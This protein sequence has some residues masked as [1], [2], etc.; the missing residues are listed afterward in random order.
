VGRVFNMMM[1]EVSHIYDEHPHDDPNA[2]LPPRTSR[3]LPAMPS[4]RR[5]SSGASMAPSRKLLISSIS[6]DDNANSG[7]ALVMMLEVSHII[8]TVFIYDEHPHDE[9]THLKDAARD[10]V[11]AEEELRCVDG[12]VEE[13]PDL[14]LHEQEERLCGHG[15]APSQYFVSDKWYLSAT[16]Q[17]VFVSDRS[18]FVSDKSLFVHEQEERLCGN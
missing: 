16:S 9:A 17:S 14:V 10:A 12:P 8:I 11:E 13:A 1:P 3:M 2:P 15:G 18:V 6:S 4:K 7:G 5:R